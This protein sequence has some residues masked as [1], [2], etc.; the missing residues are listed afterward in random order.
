MKKLTQA[1]ETV[2]RRRVSNSNHHLRRAG[3]QDG[4]F[5]ESWSGLKPHESDGYVLRRARYSVLLNEACMVQ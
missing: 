4:T 5:R 1:L 2:A 3:I